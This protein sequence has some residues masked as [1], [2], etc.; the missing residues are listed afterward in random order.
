MLVSRIMLSV[1]I[2]E[3]VKK[4]SIK[5]TAE[6]SSKSDAVFEINKLVSKTA[7]F[8]EK[9]RY[10][11]DYKEEQTV[12]RS[13]IE[14]ILKRKLFIENRNAV[15]LSLLEELVGG[16]YVA[17]KYHT[18]ETAKDIDVIINKY[19][20]LFEHVG[21]GDRLKKK[22]CSLAAS[23]VDQFLNSYQ[24]AIDTFAVEAFC[25]RVGPHIALSQATKG[26]ME[27]ALYSAAS[28]SLL[29]SDDQML[30]YALWRKMAPEWH[31]LGENDMRGFTEKFGKIISSIEEALYSPLQWQ[32]ARKIKN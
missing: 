14:R 7:T 15:G 5:D 19:L 27:T 23:E 10:L 29:G 9:I 11:V 13:A 4:S 16:Q 1:A 26:N 17:E 31:T 30:A 21:R 3:F 6:I 12:R 24:Y 20:L 28:R 22:I 18:E 25:L 2:E 8:Y 32:I